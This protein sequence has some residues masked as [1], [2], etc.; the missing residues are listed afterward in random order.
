MID[1]LICGRL[2]GK[3]VEKLSKAGKPYFTARV[4][5]PTRD[6]EA[7]FVSIIAFSRTVG[8]ALVA[9]DDSDAVALSGE[10]TLSAYL[11]K[12]GQPRPGAELLAHALLSEYHVQRKRA[13]MP[14]VTRESAETSAAPMNGAAPAASGAATESAA[15]N[16]AQPLHASAQRAPD[17][18]DPIGF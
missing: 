7:Q 18:D 6:G 15:T 1:A 9:L 16:G 3:P 12:Q 8:E 10:L 2:Y 13:A 17:F 14:K 5:V 11:D 4:R